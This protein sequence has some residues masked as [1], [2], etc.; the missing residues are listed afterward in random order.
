M[1]AHDC[2]TSIQGAHVAYDDLSVY[3]IENG[4]VHCLKVKNMHYVN[5]D[6][7]SEDINFIYDKYQELKSLQNEKSF[8]E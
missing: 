2:G 6:R 1:K 7:L 3:Q 5:T 4:R 8:G